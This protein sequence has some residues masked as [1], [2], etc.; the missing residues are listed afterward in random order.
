MVKVFSIDD[1][2]VY[3]SMKKDAVIILKSKCYP[4]IKKNLI[5]IVNQ[6]FCDKKYNN[7]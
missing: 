2:E 3:E 7:A 1:K 5:G 6:L 4:E